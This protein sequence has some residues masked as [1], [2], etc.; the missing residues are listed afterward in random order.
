MCLTVKEGCKPEIAEKDI[1]CFKIVRECSMETWRPYYISIGYK[2]LATIDKYKMMTFPYNIVI[3]AKKISYP[4]PPTVEIISDIKHLEVC[5]LVP[6]G[7]YSSVETIYNGFHSN[8]NFLSACFHNIGG[9]I[10]LC[11]IPEG[12]EYCLGDDHDI[13]STQLIVFSNLKEYIKYKL[14]KK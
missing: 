5:D 10:K 4:N 13:V 6:E 2:K 11:I 9:S 3:N 14:G 7:I 1:L 12:S 8:R